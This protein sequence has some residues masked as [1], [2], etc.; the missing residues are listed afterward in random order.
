[1]H[2][3][4]LSSTD[5]KVIALEPADVGAVSSLFASLYFSVILFTKGLIVLD[6]GFGESDGVFGS[7]L[8]S[9]GESDG[10]FGSWLLFGFGES[11]GVFGS[12]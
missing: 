12:W 9:F 1:M 4:A 8:L 11:E 6:A 5:A 3:F 7:W 2:T 10:V